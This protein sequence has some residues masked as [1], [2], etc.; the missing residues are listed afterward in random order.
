MEQ[1]LDAALEEKPSGRVKSTA[2]PV[3]VALA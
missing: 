2:P 1:V 3:P